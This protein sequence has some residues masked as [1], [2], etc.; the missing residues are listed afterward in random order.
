MAMLLSKQRKDRFIALE[1]KD[2]SEDS[3]RQHLGGVG[4]CPV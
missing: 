4:L 1:K 2:P 3:S